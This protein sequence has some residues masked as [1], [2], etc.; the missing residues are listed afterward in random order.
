MFNEHGSE[1]VYG[2]GEGTFPVRWMYVEQKLEITNG[3]DNL[4][5]V[6]EDL[7][8]DR[9]YLDKEEDHFTIPTY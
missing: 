2:Y 8:D 3:S 4:K 6:L 7:I 1:D 9:F 5:T